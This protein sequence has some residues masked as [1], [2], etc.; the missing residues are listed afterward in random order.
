MAGT[1]V[2]Q[3][4]L[5]VSGVLLMTA[6]ASAPPGALEEKYFQQEARNYLK[7]EQDGQTVY[8]QNSRQTDSLVPY[9]RCITETA[10]RQRV[11]NYR[12]ARNSVV[13][14]GPPYVSTVPGGGS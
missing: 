9:K 14:G 6:C 13:R 10:L 1:R 7:F 5:L 3:C 8:C 11:E 12:M 2:F 4:A